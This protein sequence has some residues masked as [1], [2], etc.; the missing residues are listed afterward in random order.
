M[1]ETGGYANESNQSAQIGGFEGAVERCFAAAAVVLTYYAF[2]DNFR[3]A[4][5]FLPTTRQVDVSDEPLAAL[6][7]SPFVS[8]WLA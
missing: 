4:A 5:S 3:I 1:T 8:I 6:I 7:N 2:S